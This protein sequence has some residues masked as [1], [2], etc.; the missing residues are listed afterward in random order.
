MI[1]LL[2]NYDSFTYNLVQYFG[3]LGEDVQVYRNDALTI[4]DVA[5][6]Q[7]YRPGTLVEIEIDLEERA[8]RAGLD[9]GAG[10][11]GQF[12]AAGAAGEHALAA[13]IAE[14]YGADVDEIRGWYCEDNL[15]FGEIMLALTTARASGEPADELAG[16]RVDDEGWGEIW[17]DLDLIN[18][19]QDAGEMNDR[20]S[21]D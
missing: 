14:T 4:A 12:C 9:G 5:A 1:L 6:Q 13:G 8:A 18:D 15:G 2:D 16:R 7:Y 17:Q 19:A 21:D 10:M 3:E 20:L 11:A